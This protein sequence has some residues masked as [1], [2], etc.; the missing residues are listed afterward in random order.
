MDPH[1]SVSG[2]C[3]IPRST[4]LWGLVS[5]L[6]WHISD[7]GSGFDTI[8]NNQLFTRYYSVWGYCDPHTTSHQPAPILLIYCTYALKKGLHGSSLPYMN[9]HLFVFRRCGTP[10]THT[11]SNDMKINIASGFPCYD[12]TYPLSICLCLLLLPSCYLVRSLFCCL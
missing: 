12:P 10:H 5:S 6:H 9:L 2:R 11:H 7:H 3:G 4:P 1:L 8:C